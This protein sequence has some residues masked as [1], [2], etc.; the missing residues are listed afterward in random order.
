[1]KT[2]IL[3]AALLVLLAAAPAVADERID[4]A[5]GYFGNTELV[6]QHGK[7]VSFYDDLLRDKIVVIDA[8]FT[9]CT[10]ICPVMGR[11]LKAIQTSFADRLGKDLHLISITLDP[12]HDTP[13]RLADYAERLEAGEGWHFLTGTP[14][15]V[16]GLLARLGQAVEV[17]E[18]HRAVLLV[19]NERTG[20]WK[21]AFGL[22]KPESIVEI[23]GTVL[24]DGEA[25]PTA[26]T[27]AVGR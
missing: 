20:L 19:G 8:F 11:A 2:R 3:S 14:E 25:S 1:M 18:S 21:K 17:K 13:E 9:T 23:V 22:A 4:A 27:G 15:N 12:E 5:R 10:G 24:A 26:A 7:T 16:Q 6:D